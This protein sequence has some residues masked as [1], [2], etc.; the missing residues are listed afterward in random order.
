MEIPHAQTNSI[1]D[2]IEKKKHYIRRKHSMDLEIM[3]LYNAKGRKKA[4][5]RFDKAKSKRANA[6]GTFL[7]WRNSSL[8]QAT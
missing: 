1:L 6:E 3:D 4:R 7:I 2:A 8:H 5:D